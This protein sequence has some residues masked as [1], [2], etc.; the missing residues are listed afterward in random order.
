MDTVSNN[1]AHALTTNRLCLSSTSKM[2][3][4]VGRDYESLG[5]ASKAFHDLGRRLPHRRVLQ[6]GNRRSRRDVQCPQSIG[7]EGVEIAQLRTKR[8]CRS[9]PEIESHQMFFV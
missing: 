2:P 9:R 3:D 1:D 8:Y 5:L 7:T 4:Y 6:S